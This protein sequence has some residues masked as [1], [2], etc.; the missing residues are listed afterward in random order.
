MEP[1]FCLTKDNSF[2]SDVFIPD[3]KLARVL[4]AKNLNGEVYCDY[5]GDRQ[6]AC[7]AEIRLI[8]RS[9]P[10]VDQLLRIAEAVYKIQ[11][12]DPRHQHEPGCWSLFDKTERTY[13]GCKDVLD[14]LRHAKI[15]LQT[16]LDNKTANWDCGQKFLEYLGKSIAVIMK[17]S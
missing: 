6:C 10:D 14:P 11:G 16:Y 4:N 2:K 5:L 3:S 8:D 9:N 7:R 17:S 12:G 13:K 15:N 1:M